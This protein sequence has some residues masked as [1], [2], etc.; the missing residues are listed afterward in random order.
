MRKQ[1][2]KTFVAKIT[3]LVGDID[4]RIASLQEVEV[5]LEQHDVKGEL[6][7]ALEA[8][9][10][11]EFFVKTMAE[12]YVSGNADMAAS[13]EPRRLRLSGWEYIQ[14]SPESIVE[15]LVGIKVKLMLKNKQFS[16]IDFS[17]EW[18]M[19]RAADMSEDARAAGQSRM[20]ETVWDKIASTCPNEEQLLVA[21][22]ALCKPFCPELSSI[23]SHTR[24][25]KRQAS[26]ASDASSSVF[27]LCVDADQADCD[28]EGGEAE[29]RA[30]P[31]QLHA[32]H[33][34]VGRYQVCM[35]DGF[36]RGG[37]GSGRVF[38][39]FFGEGCWGWVFRAGVFGVGL[40]ITI[41]ESHRRI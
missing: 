37:E 14:M 6:R 2:D 23:S 10:E 30:Q 20:E 5:P 40:S 11:Y 32:D 21:I 34:R 39:L 12:Y 7:K 36:S 35:K 27:E 31:L 9:S 8:T 28:M 38:G 18:Y 1:V 19:I 26:T 33:V 29:M 13:Y 17:P 3:K 15:D 16:D 25:L 22:E 41:L 4:S 24:G